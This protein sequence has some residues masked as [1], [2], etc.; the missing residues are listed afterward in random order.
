MPTRFCNNS[1][2]SVEI[3]KALKVTEILTQK[4]SEYRHGQKPD[5]PRCFHASADPLM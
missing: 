4:R 3:I 1:K 5:T 2:N